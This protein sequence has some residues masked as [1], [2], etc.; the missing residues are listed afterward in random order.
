MVVGEEY[1]IKYVY[2][3]EFP[4]EIWEILSWK[5]AKS[6]VNDELLHQVDVELIQ[7]RSAAASSLFSHIKAKHIASN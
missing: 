7:R 5:L 3:D 1:H 2:C 4:P 6:A